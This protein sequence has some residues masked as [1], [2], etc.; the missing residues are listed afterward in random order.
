[1]SILDELS[2]YHGA[3]K[4]NRVRLHVPAHSPM[5]VSGVGEL[6]PS[7]NRGG[8]PED[9]TTQGSHITEWRF[10]SGPKELVV[11]SSIDTSEHGPLLHVSA[12]Y[13]K[14]L[15]PWETMIA[16]RSHFFPDTVDVAMVMP[17]RADYV[18]MHAYCFH[19]WQI[20]VEWGIQ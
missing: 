16:L 15:P 18:N 10:W 5:R 7:S 19:L 20:P 8:W 13:P 17:R 1:M 14:H 12:S 2:R 4:P 3:G 11:G 6:V 9:V